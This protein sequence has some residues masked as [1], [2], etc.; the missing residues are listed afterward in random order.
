MPA[1]IALVSDFVAQHQSGK[2]RMLA[3]AGSQRS[4]VTPDV[5]TFKELGFTGIDVTG[6]HAVYAPAGTPRPIV[7]LI[8]AAVASAIKDPEVSE[9]LRALGL[10]PV[11]STADELAARMV[12]DTAKWA[13]AVKASGFRAEE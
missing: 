8:S 7:E 10:E 6:W 1:G 3:T 2:V 12:D 5:P 13:P 4:P 9:R 11:G